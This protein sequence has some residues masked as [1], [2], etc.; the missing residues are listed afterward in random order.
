[1]RIGRGLIACA[2]PTADIEL[3]NARHHDHGVWPVAVLEHGKFQGFGA[4]NEQAAAQ[5]SLI[6]DDPLATAVLANQE[7]R[8]V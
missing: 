4:A 6:P 1:L 7:E 5:A 8:R 3:E 2:R